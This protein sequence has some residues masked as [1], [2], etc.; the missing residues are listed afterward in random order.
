MD[1]KNGLENNKN[2]IDKLQVQIIDVVDLVDI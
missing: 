2:S 1:G